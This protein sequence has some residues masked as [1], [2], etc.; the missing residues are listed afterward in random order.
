MSPSQVDLAVSELTDTVTGCSSGL[1]ESLARA[2]YQAGHCIVAT[3]R[4]VESLSYLPDD[5][6]PERNPTVLKLALDVTSPESID[7][8]IKESLAYFQK[9]DVFINNAGYGLLG[10]MEA[11]PEP[12]ARRLMET[13]F[14]GPVNITKAALQ[15]F[16]ETKGQFTTKTIVQ[17][18]S[19]GGWITAP[20]HSFYHAR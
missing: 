10:E 13:N 8:A 4:N 2:I 11:I 15:L 18:T 17:V 14:W 9:I 7:N 1:G 3:A 5:K 12:E 20:G 19:M 16:R 6:D